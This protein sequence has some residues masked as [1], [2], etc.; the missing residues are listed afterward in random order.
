MGIGI[1]I[2]AGVL[3]L[4]AIA[5]CISR[6][7]KKFQSDQKEDQNGMRLITSD[8]ITES[9]RFRKALVFFCGL[10]VVQGFIV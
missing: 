5:S 1:S 3:S 4:Y 6:M 8:N 10:I 2:V 9:T 7:K